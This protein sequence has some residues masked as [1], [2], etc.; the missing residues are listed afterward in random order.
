MWPIDSL[1]RNSLCR[2]FMSRCRTYTLCLNGSRAV[3]LRYAQYRPV[4][5]YTQTIGYNCTYLPTRPPSRGPD[6]VHQGKRW[7]L[8]L[9]RTWRLGEPCHCADLQATCYHQHKSAAR[10]VYN[11]E[12]FSFE[13]PSPR[14]NRTSPR[15]WSQLSQQLLRRMASITAIR[16]NKAQTRLQVRKLLVTQALGGLSLPF[17]AAVLRAFPY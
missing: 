13:N 2:F 15:P 8:R 17:G 10:P 12:D 4:Q 1:L 6:Y 16:R 14:M 7:C 3:Y 9:N 11:H 5:G